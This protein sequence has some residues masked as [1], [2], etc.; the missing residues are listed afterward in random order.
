MQARFTFSPS[1][2]G[3]GQ[4]SRIAEAHS[5][6]TKPASLFEARIK[7][8]DNW[9]ALPLNDAMTIDEGMLAQ[10][11]WIDDKIK[12]D[13][14]AAA[15]KLWANVAQRAPVLNA[16]AETSKASIIATVEPLALASTAQ[17]SILPEMTG[18][19]TGGKAPRCGIVYRTQIPARVRICR[20][21][22]TDAMA[23]TTAC[24]G[25]SGGTGQVLFSEDRSIPQ[26]G[27]L[28]SLGLKNDAFANTVLTAEWNAEGTLL[29]FGYKKPRAQAVEFARTV[30]AGLDAATTLITYEKG[31]DLRDLAYEKQL[32]DARVAAINSGKPLQQPSQVTQVDNETNLLDA[33]RK[34]IEAE[35]NLHK[36]RQELEALRAEAA[37]GDE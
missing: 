13:P 22:G 17:L 36:K 35:I 3:D 4:L 8:D 16:A 31:T 15:R 21:E 2:G 28:A 11:R 27:Q 18:C 1:A 7:L 24:N 9:L 33:E 26:L 29:K 14:E 20:V 19:G 25:F 32:N 5:G 37:G 10:A 23:A 6:A 30:N 12:D 34:R